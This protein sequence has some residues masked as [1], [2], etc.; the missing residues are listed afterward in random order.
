MKTIL[1]EIKRITKSFSEQAKTF[2]LLLMVFIFIGINTTIQAQSG[3]Y[4]SYAILK[5]N[6]GG[7]A[8][9]NLQAS[10]G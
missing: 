9:Y 5:I 6:G 2:R 3:I 8:Y 7:N 1:S 4:E 10:T